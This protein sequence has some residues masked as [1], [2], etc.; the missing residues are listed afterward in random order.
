MTEGTDFDF[1]NGCIDYLCLVT[2]TKTN[3]KTETF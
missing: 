1:E 3:Q 2:M